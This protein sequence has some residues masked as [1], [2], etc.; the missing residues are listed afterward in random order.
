MGPGWASMIITTQSF[1]CPMAAQSP[2]PIESQ[3]TLTQHTEPRNRQGPARPEACYLP[4]ASSRS[5][6]T[7]SAGLT[8][9]Q[10]VGT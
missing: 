5:P 9:Y 4:S 8:S 2:Q 3:P 6:G 10:V 1:L 7:R